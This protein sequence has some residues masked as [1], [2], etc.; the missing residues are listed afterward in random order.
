M[1]HPS[2]SCRDEIR[3]GVEDGTFLRAALPQPQLA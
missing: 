1:F 3:L 2:L